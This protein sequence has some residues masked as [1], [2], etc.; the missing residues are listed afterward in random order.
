MGL[1]RVGSGPVRTTVELVRPQ[2]VTFHGDSLVGAI[3]GDDVVCGAHGPAFEQAKRP[4]QRPGTVRK[5]RFVGLGAQVVVVEDEAG[6]V[7]RAEEQADGPE[8]VRRDYSSGWRRSARRG[9]L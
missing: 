6:P 7:Q 9:W 4:V 8:D 3:R 2:A 1:S 5:A